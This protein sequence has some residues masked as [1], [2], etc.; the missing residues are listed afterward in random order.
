M[1]WPE[2][3]AWREFEVLVE[4]TW[5]AGQSIDWFDKHLRALAE[6]RG[7]AVALPVADRRRFRAFSLGIYRRY[8]KIEY[9]RH[10]LGQLAEA[11]FSLWVYHLG[12]GG[13]EC[14]AEHAKF[15]GIALSP[16]HLFWTFFL[17]PNAPDCSCHVSGTW[18]VAGVR[19]MGGDPDK[20]LPV[21]WMAYLP[22]AGWRGTDWLDLRGIFAEALADLAE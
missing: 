2:P 4:R 1:W 16:D 6:R 15:D 18:T 14:A 3:E 5:Q 20:Q 17:P 11:S 10:R 22:P 21:D 12:V 19:R 13:G 8:G 7:W 9:A